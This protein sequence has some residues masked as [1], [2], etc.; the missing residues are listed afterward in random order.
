MNINEVIARA[1]KYGTIQSVRRI[2]TP[3]DMETAM[4][5]V[6]MIGRAIIP[7]FVID[8]ENRWVYEQLIKWVHAD[9]TMMAQEP[10]TKA[11]VKGRLNAGI[12]LAGNTGSGKSLALHIMS[13]YRNIYNTQV[14]INEESFCLAWHPIRVDQICDAYAKTGDIAKYKKMPILCVQ[15]FGSEPSETLYMGN[16]LNVMQQIIEARGDLGD[17][18][19]LISSNASVKNQTLFDR[20]G[21]R[22]ISRLGEMCNYIELKGTDRRIRTNH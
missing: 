21:N 6:L 4:A 8:N 22:V 10:T 20:Y 7:H 5:A 12:Y 16:R 9:D 3:Y 18:I 13:L 19:T 15:D 14:L 1:R 11:Q 2:K 17:V